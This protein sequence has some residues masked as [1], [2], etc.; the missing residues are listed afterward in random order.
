MKSNASILAVYLAITVTLQLTPYRGHSQEPPTFVQSDANHMIAVYDVNGHPI[1]NGGAETEGSP[2][3]ITKWTMGWLRLADGRMFTGVSLQLDLEKQ[4]VY[5]KRLDG[6]EI[7]VEQGQVHQLAMLDTI[8]GST[9]A[10]Q[11]GSGYPPIDNQSE[12][13]FYLLLDSG[14]VC[15]LESIRK[16]LHQEKD[17]FAGTNS[18]EYKVYDDFYVYVQGKMTRVKKDSKF[19][20]ELTNDKHDQMDAWLKQNKV[21]FKSMEDIRQFIHYY[22]G[23]P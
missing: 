23:L 19:F 8:A 1:V 18:R 12:T 21:S 20:L 4:K 2:L 22:N 16:R 17:D 5:Y 13:S 11:F 9:V 14:R 10:Y 3:F 15:F 6:I 7:A